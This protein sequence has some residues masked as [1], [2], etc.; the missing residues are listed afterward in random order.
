MKKGSITVFLSLSLAGVMIFIF[1]LLDITRLEGQRRKAQAISEIATMS[2]FA[3]YNRY[4]WDNYR[5]LAVDASYGSG[6]GADFAVM[7]SGMGE[8]LRKNGLSTDT[9]GMSLYQLNTSKCEV[10][11]YGL[12]T[13]DGGRA[14]MKQ[15][16]KQQKY[17]IPEKLLDEAVDRSDSINSDA[18]D[19]Q[20]VDE[21]MEAGN[22]A[23]KKADDIRERTADTESAKPTVKETG[24]DMGVT[25]VNL[26]VA[27]NVGKEESGPDMKEAREAE[28]A[29][30]PMEDI[31]KWKDNAILAQ[32]LPSSVRIS[33]KS[34]DLTNAVSRRTLACGNNGS[35]PGLTAVEKALFAD[36]EKTHF[37]SY[38]NDLSH[39]GLMY[40]WEYVL[41][42]KD[43]DRENL[44]ATVTKL[45]ALREVENLISI[46][47][48]QDKCLQA[49]EAAEAIAGWTGNQAIVIAVKWGLIAS[50]A[51][52]ES[53]LDVR[54]LLS[55]G[56]VSL[57]K[58]KEDWT[59]DNLMELTEFFDVKKKAKEAENGITYEGYMLAMSA[60]QSDK[61]LGLRSLDLLENSLKLQEHYRECSMDQMVVSARMQFEYS[62]VPAFFSLYALS[63][64]A[65]PVLTIRKHTELSYLDDG[66][67]D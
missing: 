40:E 13:D 37:S 33:D 11:K 12:L 7:E 62:S 41:C 3:D 58:N 22:N 43:S 65:F 45:I 49:L 53:V 19:G 29:S 25:A 36:Y 21:L 48:D 8:Y 66:S 51:Y 67:A 16:A 61:T 39:D 2:V 32:V 34:I 63:S 57:V 46:C 31:T 47:S 6:G 30:N 20:S 15:A 54:L 26:S 52:V 23:V 42:G 24:P 4:L 1:L 14:F 44:S 38:T 28:K 18:S 5:I 10:T 17:E 27:V 56:K 9:P 64:R 60:L 59:T 50:W 55:G 35:V